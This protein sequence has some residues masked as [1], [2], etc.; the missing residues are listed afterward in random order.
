VS[1]GVREWAH[2]EK[3]GVPLGVGRWVF[4]SRT[5][6]KLTHAPAEPSRDHSLCFTDTGVLENFRTRAAGPDEKSVYSKVT[7]SDATHPW[8]GVRS[9]SLGT[10]VAA[11]RDS[12]HTPTRRD[13]PR[14]RSRAGGVAGWRLGRSSLARVE[15]GRRV[16]LA[17]PRRPVVEGP[18]PRARQRGT[19][20][21]DDSLG[22]CTIPSPPGGACDFA[23]QCRGNQAC[24]GS[25][26]NSSGGGFPD[27][28]V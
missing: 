27:A 21:L 2:V 28:G 23:L 14:D 4:T 5:R 9:R 6:R 13:G 15:S 1:E 19:R 3:R 16:H 11:E 22:V 26:R 8:R 7:N 10:L 18:W 12:L 25:F 17:H 24:T 20:G